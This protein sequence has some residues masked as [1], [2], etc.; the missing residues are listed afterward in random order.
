M[1][2]PLLHKEEDMNVH[3]STCGTEGLEQI[4]WTRPSSSLSHSAAQG[5]SDCLLRSRLANL[6]RN[7]I[8]S[9]SVSMPGRHTMSLK[10]IM[11]LSTLAERCTLGP[12]P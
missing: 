4:E 3:A 8:A 1:P 6:S 5:M 9:L 2:S 7:N 11:S 10:A 12:K